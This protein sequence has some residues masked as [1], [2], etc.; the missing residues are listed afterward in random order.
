MW[1]E[2]KIKMQWTERLQEAAS[3]TLSTLTR[4]EYVGMKSTALAASAAGDDVSCF[5]FLI[6]YASE[7]ALRECKSAKFVFVPNSVLQPI[8]ESLSAPFPAL[9]K[10][11]DD[12]VVTVICRANNDAAVMTDGGDEDKMFY[13]SYVYTHEHTQK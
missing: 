11:K 12:D 13:A 4:A 6:L 2:A 5:S 3:H 9:I 1:T 7:A 10:G 8:L